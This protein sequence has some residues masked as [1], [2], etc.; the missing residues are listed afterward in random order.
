MFVY[1]GIVHLLQNISFKSMINIIVAFRTIRYFFSIL[2]FERAR[3]IDKKNIFIIHPQKFNNFVKV[4]IQ[5]KRCQVIENFA[6]NLLNTE[7]TRC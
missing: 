4:W 2:N 5:T 1:I 7:T 3:H 6:T